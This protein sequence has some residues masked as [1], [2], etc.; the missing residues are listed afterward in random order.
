M[1]NKEPIDIRK[2][3]GLTLAFSISFILAMLV[4]FM[5]D[6]ASYISKFLNGIIKTLM[7][8]LIGACLAYIICPMVNGLNLLY[9][10]LFKKL[11][12]ERRFALANSFSIYTGIIIA[13]LIIIFVI[14]MIIPNLVNSIIRIVQ[15]APSAIDK[16]YDFAINFMQSNEFIR[17]HSQNIINTSYDFAK[18]YINNNLVKNSDV[19]LSNLTIGVMGVLNLLFNLLIG[20]IVAIYLLFMRKKLAKQGKMLIYSIFKEKEAES[21]MDEFEFVDKVFS[22]FLI[23]KIVDAIV[24]AIICYFLLIFYKLLNPGVETMNEVMI[25][26]IVGIFNV[27]PFFGWCIAWAIGIILC[28]I[29]NPGQAIYFLVFNFILQ[30]IDGNII[31]PKILGN[32]TGISGF[33]VLFAILLFGHIWGFFGMLIGV[34]IFAIIYHFIKK[35]IFKGLL[36]KGQFKMAVDYENE[37]PTKENEKFSEKM[38]TAYERIKEDQLKQKEE[39][40]KLKEE[41]AKQKEEQKR[42]KEELKESKRLKKENK[43][44][45]ENIEID[46]EIEED[47]EE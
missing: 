43:Q 16:F 14:V 3:L 28:L 1:K 7:P 9:Q 37:Y 34:P 13:A 35:A 11:K 29:V 12:E 18:D 17:E 4:Y 5:I 10:K 2:Y 20:F 6:R 38:K 27:I 46:S 45:E 39:N 23:G 8:F 47:E 15:L 33:W 19:I 21:I 42:I 44:K 25:A 24:I 22:G 26:V 36:K 30:Q 40:A 31:G 32:S 41:I